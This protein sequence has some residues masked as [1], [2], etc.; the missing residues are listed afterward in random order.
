MFAVAIDVSC[1]HE[2]ATADQPSMSVQ[3]RPSGKRTSSGS[4]AKSNATGV[5]AG[6]VTKVSLSSPQLSASASRGVV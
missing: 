1:Q 3:A 4:T 5:K 2:C 6:R